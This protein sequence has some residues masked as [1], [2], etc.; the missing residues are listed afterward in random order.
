MILKKNICKNYSCIKKVLN[1]KFR[2][3]N[4]MQ[5]LQMKIF[6]FC[7][8]DFHVWNKI[9]SLLIFFRNSSLNLGDLFQAGGIICRAGC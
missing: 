9:F 5:L 4:P 1:A 2:K 8:I 6:P 3:L 7:S